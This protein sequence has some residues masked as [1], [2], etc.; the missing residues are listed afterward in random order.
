MGGISRAKEIFLT[1]R[2]A[3]PLMVL[4]LLPLSAQPGRRGLDDAVPPGALIGLPG[5]GEAGAFCPLEHTSVKAEITGPLR[6]LRWSSSFRI[7]SVKRSKPCI[8]SR[9]PPMRLLT[10]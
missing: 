9:C 8:R 1:M 6:A 3:I 10:T 7:R 4:S 2:Y 5:N